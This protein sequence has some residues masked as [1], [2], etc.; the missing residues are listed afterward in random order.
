MFLDQSS[1]Y[2]RGGCP[3][4]SLVNKKADSY[5]PQDTLVLIWGVYNSECSSIPANSQSPPSVPLQKTR[6][7]R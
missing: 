1:R 2:N 3:E 7:C 4:L 6:G 5:T